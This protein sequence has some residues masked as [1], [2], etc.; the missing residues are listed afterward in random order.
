VMLRVLIP[1]PSFGDD[2][3][4]QEALNLRQDHSQRKMMSEVDWKSVT[5]KFIPEDAVMNK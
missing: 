1:N 3:S 5:H 2:Y 4:H